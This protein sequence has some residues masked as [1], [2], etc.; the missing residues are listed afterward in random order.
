MKRTLHAVMQLG[1][2]DDLIKE[3][4]KTTVKQY[5][6]ELR[7]NPTHSHDQP[8]TLVTKPD[9]LKAKQHLRHMCLSPI[10]K[11]AGLTAIMCPHV[12]WLCMRNAW[13][14][15]PDR[16]EVICA[17]DASEETVEKTEREILTQDIK[18]YHEKNWQ[19]IAKLYGVDPFGRPVNAALPRGYSNP[20]L[21]AILAA[22]PGRK[23]SNIIKARPIA[24]HT[25]I[26]LKN[27]TNRN[28]T[29]HHFL[30]TQ[31]NTGRQTRMWTTSEYPRWLR[32]EQLAL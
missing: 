26:P 13:P 27:V 22:V 8:V 4:T 24:P 21:K 18:I 7:Q 14:D 5:E 20:K 31:I 19:R 11:G 15:E 25:K 9:V 30:L 6:A 32:D 28:A 12:M 10:D 3:I 2:T 17:A 23:A 1:A 16:C 29:G